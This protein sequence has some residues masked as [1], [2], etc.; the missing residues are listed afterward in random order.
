MK[1]VNYVIILLLIAFTSCSEIQAPEFVK[2]KELKV[3]KLGMNEIIVKGEIEY[4]N[5]NSVGGELKACN[6]K[7]RVND[8]DLGSVDQTFSTQIAA[9]DH[10]KVPV[11]IKFSPKK[12]FARDKGFLNGLLNAALNKKVKV[13]YE[14]EAILEFM[15]IDIKVPIEHEEEVPLK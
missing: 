6:L 12:V 9:K 10:F 13:Y 11:Q 14:G 5:P 3:H 2:F 8:L 7:V 1:Y 4:F 15:D